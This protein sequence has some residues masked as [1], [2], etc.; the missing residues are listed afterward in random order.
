[1]EDPLTNSGGHME[2]GFTLGSDSIAFPNLKTGNRNGL[3]LYTRKASENCQAPHLKIAVPMKYGFKEF[4]G[5]TD[6]RNITR[7]SIDIFEAAM[8]TLHSTPCYDYFIFHGTYDEIV[9]NV[10]IGVRLTSTKNFVSSSDT[11][12]CVTFQFAVPKYNLISANLLG[13]K[14]VYDAA[15]G[16]LTVTA[17]Q[18]NASMARTLQC[19]T[20]SLAWLCLSR[21]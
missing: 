2:F 20:H 17:E 9:G 6:P 16:D 13:D 1:M 21:Q 3:R 8:R 12:S 10:S 5:A 18:L 19:H 14:Q 4:V 11:V 15:V 7:Y